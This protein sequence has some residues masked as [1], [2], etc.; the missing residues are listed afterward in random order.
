MNQK[1]FHLFRNESNY[2]QA[3][4]TCK[5]NGNSTLLELKSADKFQ[6]FV[7]YLTGINCEYHVLIDLKEGEED[8]RVFRWQ[9]DGTRV[10]ETFWAPGEPNSFNGNKHG[11]ECAHLR[12]DNGFRINDTPC[13][14]KT[15]F[16][17]E[18]DMF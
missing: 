10:N 6:F 14:F 7:D 15:Y 5:S 18:K 3:R 11:E 9:S 2:W 13:F 17:C 1:C 8:D 16:I 4:E 12:R